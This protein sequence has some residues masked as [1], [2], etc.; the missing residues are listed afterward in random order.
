MLAAMPQMPPRIPLAVKLAY[1]AFIAVWVPVYWTQN[2]WQ[3]FLWLCDL[4]NFLILVGLWLE[5][6]LLISAQA[7][8]VLLVQTIWC[9]DY[10]GALLFGVH[11]V[12]GTEYMFDTSKPLWLRGFSLFHVAI[13]PLL[14]WAVRR[15]GYDRR[16]WLLQTAIT[17][18]LL[19]LTYLVVER[20]RNI[21][22]VWDPFGRPQTLLPPTGYLVALLALYP[23]LLYLPTHLLLAW[24]DGRSA[25]RASPAALDV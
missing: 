22:W 13:P 4:A 18:A 2:S 5:S 11:P 9:V 7:C 3:N 10:F 24:W 23:L 19:P 21:N 17:W 15:L 6:P 8:G 25:R 20:E 12:G 14:L 1:T 16:G